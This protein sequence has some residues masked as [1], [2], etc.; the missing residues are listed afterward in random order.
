MGNFKKVLAK[1]WEYI[2]WTLD[3]KELWAYF[4]GSSVMSSIFVSFI[5][6]LKNQPL[7]VKI[8]LVIGIA[9]LLFAAIGHLISFVNLYH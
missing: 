8:I 5:P 2:G 3:A 4:G 9:S 7:S 6:V 1:L